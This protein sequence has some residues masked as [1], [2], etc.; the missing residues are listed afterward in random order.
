MTATE[1]F[2]RTDPGPPRVWVQI[3]EDY[4]VSLHPV[5]QTTIPSRKSVPLNEMVLISED[6]L[7]LLS[8]CPYARGAFFYRILELDGAL[9][10]I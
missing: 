4:M 6:L 7:V 8:W 5:A 9:E 1:S 10:A 2:F 3:A